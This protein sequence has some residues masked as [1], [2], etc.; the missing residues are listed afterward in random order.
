MATKLTLKNIMVYDYLRR[1]RNGDQSAST[2]KAVY[3]ANKDEI[4]KLFG[5]GNYQGFN[6]HVRKVID[7][8]TST[9]NKVKTIR[10]DNTENIGGK[11]VSNENHA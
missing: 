10:L 2:V 4:K 3:T 1:V 5:I 11:E 8:E 6:F 7:W 9:G